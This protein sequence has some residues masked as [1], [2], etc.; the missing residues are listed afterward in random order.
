LGSFGQAAS[1][2]K[3]GTIWALGGGAATA[4]P[5]TRGI[6]P[7]AITH[8]TKPKPANQSRFLICLILSPQKWS[9]SCHADFVA[10]RVLTL[11]Q[12]E[13]AS[14][15]LLVV[16]PSIFVKRYRCSTLPK[17]ELA[18][19]RGELVYFGEVMPGTA[20]ENTRRPLPDVSEVSLQYEGSFRAVY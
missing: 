7:P 6:A 13:W 12:G 9:S 5:M 11:H 3:T 18:E 15:C 14:V 20:T 19:Q 4:R 8:P 2:S 1:T 17:M 16:P 10:N